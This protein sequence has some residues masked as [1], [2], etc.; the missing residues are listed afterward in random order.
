MLKNFFKK[1]NKKWI[2]AGIIVLVAIILFSNGFFKKENGVLKTEKVILGTLIQEVSETGMLKPTKEIKLGF[3]TAGR[4]EK[5]N[6]EV[7]DAVGEGTII[8]SLDKIQLFI[9]LNQ[10]QASLAVA[11]SQYDK[12][13]AGSTP[14]EIK[15]Y[16]NARSSAQQDLDDAYSDALNT[17]DDAYLKIYN[18]Y[19][20]VDT[21]QYSYFSISDQE[22]IKVVDNKA[23]IN[24]NLNAVKPLLDEAKADSTPEKIDNTIVEMLASL[25]N[26]SDALKTIREMCEQGIYYSKV[27]STDKTS[28]DNQRSY[29]LTA[30]TNTTNAQQTINSDKIGLQTAE[31]D[32]VL[33]KAKPRQ[34]DINYYSAKVQEAQANILSLQHQ[35]ADASLRAPTDGTITK[36][37]KKSGE[38]VQATEMPFSLI[39]SDPLQVEVDIYEEDIVKIKK[40]N[41]VDIIIA[42]FPTETLKGK[43]ISIDPAEKV[44]AGVVY[45]GITIAFDELKDNMKPGMTADV[46]IKTA[47]KEN[48][49]IIPKG[50]VKKNDKITVLVYKDGITEEREI[51]IGLEGNDNKVEVVSGLSEGEEIVIK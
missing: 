27:S 22:G 28:L 12:L 29:V 25:K 31:D 38:T 10:A 34:E 40:D 49:L 32:L 50:A 36:V 33:K 13:L 44:I 5:I 30:F 3:K 37:D 43:V 14:E 45:Y 46:V 19:N 23:L 42:A 15:I 35:I 9:Q 24:T 16:E 4:I 8:A 11:Q 48:V 6:V 7:G 51:Q 17:L 18:A 2:I 1:L 26:T 47:N 39:S 21:I 41:P 20:T